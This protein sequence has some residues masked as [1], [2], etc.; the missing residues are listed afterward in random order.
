MRGGQASEDDRLFPDDFGG[1][2]AA[3]PLSIFRHPGR[4][5]LVSLL[6]GVWMMLS[7]KSILPL[8]PRATSGASSK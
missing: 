4:E 1:V 7:A 3:H 5:S 6:Y 2:A 8:S